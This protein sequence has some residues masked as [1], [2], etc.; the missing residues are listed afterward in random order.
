MNGK[1]ALLSFGASSLFIIIFNAL[2]FIIGGAD[3]PA[4]VWFAYAMIHFA[5]LMMVATP[6]FT[7]KSKVTEEISLPLVGLSG[8]YLLAELAIGLIFMA[9]RPESLT[10]E[11]VIQ[12]LVTGIY[13]VILLVLMHSNEHTVEAV[14]EREAEAAYLAE[15]A[16]LD[17]DIRTLVAGASRKVLLFGDR[18]PFLYFAQE[19]GLSHYAAFSGCSDESEV[20]AATVAF[21]IDKVKAEKI[22]VVF[23]VELSSGRIADSICSATG[24]QKRMLHS[25]SNVSSDE[26]GA[27]ATYLS[28]MRQNLAALAE[29]LR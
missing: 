13:L 9:L 24:A 27:G 12:I 21:L 10:A 4:S 2:F 8:L 1:K 18:F 28:L 16:A 14:Q 3:H 19:Y 11:L 6:Y 29:A 7:T 17:A 26:F 5:Y 15:L 25:V 23:T 22:P 20:S